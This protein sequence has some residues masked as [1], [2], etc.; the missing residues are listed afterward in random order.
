MHQGFRF[1]PTA[2][3]RDR[4]VE[5]VRITR[6]LNARFT[7]RVTTIV[8]AAGY[9]KSTAL[10]LAVE[11]NRLDPI[12][13]DVW[14]SAI[15]ADR[16]PI[17]FMNGIAVALDVVATGSDDTIEKIADALWSAAPTEVALIIDD[18]HHVIGTP[19]S[20]MLQ[21]LLAAMPTNAHL[22]LG[23]RRPIDLTL[24]R[25]RAQG[26]LLEITEADL[27]LDDEEIAALVRR[28]S[29]HV[30]PDTA[31]LPR[32]VA[33]A[34]L[35][36][37]AGS[38]A[39]ADFLWEEILSALDP[40]RLMH[41]RRAAVLDELDDQLVLALTDENFNAASLLDGIPLVDRIGDTGRRM[42]AIL[43]E[44]LVAR[45]E[46]GEERKTLSIAGDAERARAQFDTAAQLFQRAGDDIAAM[47]A[48][49]DYVLTPIV[50]QSIDSTTTVKR[51]VDRIDS[52]SP[53]ALALEAISRFGSLEHQL[54]PLFEAAAAA[55]RQRDDVELEVAA[56]NR[57]MQ[58]MLLDHR[59]EFA[60]LVERAEELGQSS[61]T[62][63]SV[64]AHFRSIMWQLEG[65]ADRSIAELAHLNDLDA[66]REYVTR[67]S[68]LCD[69]GRP[70]EV[71]I[72][73][74]PDEIARLPPGADLFVGLALWKRGAVDHATAITLADGITQSVLRR[75][76]SQPTISALATTTLVALAAGETALGERYSR[77]AVELMNVGVGASIV[78]LVKIA[79]AAVA[80]VREGDEAAAVIVAEPTGWSGNNWP[81]RGQLM[82]VPL[83]YICDPSTRPLLENRSFG[84]SV[85]MAVRAGA[86]VVA[87]REH[88]DVSGA[89]ALPWSK[90]NLLRA[91]ILPTHLVE[92]ACAA[93][94]GGSDMAAD[95]LDSTPN[96]TDLLHRVAEVSSPCAAAVAS[97]RLGA[98]PVAEPYRLHAAVLG[99]VVLYRNDVRVEHVA[100]T[101]RP[102]VR[103]LF[104]VL[105]ERGT[106]QRDE[107]CDLLWPDHDDEEKALASLRTALSTLNDV[108]E[109]DRERGA[110]AFHLHVEGDVVTLD[111]RVSTD[112]VEFEELLSSAQADDGAGL[113]ARALETYRQAAGMYR[114]SYLQGVDASWIVLPRLRIQTLA[115]SAMCRVAE[116]TAAK[117]EPEEA[118]RWVARARQIDPLNERAGLIFVAALDAAGDRSAARLAATDLV[119]TLRAAGLEPSPA[120]HR[121]IARLT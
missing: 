25:L 21:M 80:A 93:I 70:E 7:R 94:A 89:A 52:T 83:V 16:D 44:A 67:A 84:P 48:A 78:D 43:R 102:K 56:L 11:N 108:L 15:P 36:M 32:H 62:A 95:V 10:A 114:G 97:K 45:L 82:S 60:P 61:N 28:P 35:Q 69:L 121:L 31:Q 74:G 98:I 119:D 47:D 107:L 12:G 19:A 1:E 26:D 106:M 30:A 58:A 96:L 5:R 65:D 6:L 57:V 33:S 17:H 13:Q 64:A 29:E 88:D 92:L 53:T 54:I 120:I 4:I 87:L 34:D 81:S 85:S 39:S 49:R 103:E 38:N 24:A 20:A 105:L 14:I 2:V 42:H 66:A 71:A 73:I 51:V 79:R 9:G 104:A 91:H 115:V 99:A 63:R 46:P 101:K 59:P 41:L 112:L 117:G 86:A 109:P 110:A 50:H 18:V 111:H 55:A 37:A 40:D 77:H 113:P 100:F 76:F 68:R 116:L 22:V 118:A 27:E 23:S 90:P 72:G 8:G 3:Q 75:G